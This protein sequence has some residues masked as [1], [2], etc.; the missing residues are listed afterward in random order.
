MDSIDGGMFG[1]IWQLGIAAVLLAVLV[2]LIKA[3]R[4]RN[5][6]D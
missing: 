5:R 6:G 4:D 2:G 1:L 3:Y